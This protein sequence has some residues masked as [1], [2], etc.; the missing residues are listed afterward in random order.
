MSP[1]EIVQ[2]ILVA[3]ATHADTIAAAAVAAVQVRL[4][5]PD[6]ETWGPWTASGITKTVRRFN[7]ADRR[8]LDRYLA[9]HPLPHVEFVLDDAEA[10]AF[11]PMAYADL[12]KPIAKMQVSGTDFDRTSTRASALAADRVVQVY[13]RDDLTTG[14]AAAQAAHALGVFIESA[15]GAFRLQVDL[16]TET[17]LMAAASS[18]GAVVISDAGRTEVEPGT[19]TAV[20]LD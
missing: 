5:H 18:G 7:D 8:R 11:A 20:A 1:E 3:R 12:P 17:A 9:E 2:P 4:A 14:K 13:V 16:V 19:I 10:I 15:P 6:V